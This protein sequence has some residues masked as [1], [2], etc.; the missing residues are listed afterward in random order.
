MLIRRQLS[1]YDKLI[2]SHTAF[3]GFDFPVESFQIQGARQLAPGFNF[4]PLDHLCEMF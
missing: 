2:L 4:Q 3:D 1:L